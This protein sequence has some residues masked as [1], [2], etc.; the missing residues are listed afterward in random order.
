MGKKHRKKGNGNGKYGWLINKLSKVAYGYVREDISQR[1][2]QTDIVQRLP[3]T[4]FTDEA[5]MLGVNFLAK[6]LGANKNPLLG[7]IIRAQET[8][9]LARIG[10]TFKDIRAAKSTIGTDLAVS[11][12]LLF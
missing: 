3:A 12:G 5:V 11:G 10:Q 1:L 2:S 9:E 4:E 7:S 8:V 6:K